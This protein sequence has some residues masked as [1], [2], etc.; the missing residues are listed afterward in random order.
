MN[1]CI[2]LAEEAC[3]H[4]GVYFVVETLEFLHR[5]GRIG[6]ATRFIGSALNL[7]PILELKDGR[8]EAH[9]RVRTK[10]KALDRVSNWSV[11]KSKANQRSVF[12]RCMQMLRK[13]PFNCSTAPQ[14]SWG[15]LKV[16]SPPS[17][18]WLAFMP[19]QGQWH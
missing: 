2:A 3:R 6:G 12:L 16:F 15:R 10:G 14:P 1:D 11:N 17:A 18:L 4:V 7:K 13:K 9:D 5:G 19:A 8:I